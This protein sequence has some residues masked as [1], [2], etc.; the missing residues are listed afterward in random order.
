[1]TTMENRFSR[2][3]KHL[4]HHHLLHGALYFPEEPEEVKQYFLL[5]HLV[6]F[7]VKELLTQHLNYC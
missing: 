5:L 6:D 1:M 4:S 3:T 7:Q 2:E